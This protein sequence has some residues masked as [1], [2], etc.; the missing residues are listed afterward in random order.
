MQPISPLGVQFRVGAKADFTTPLAAV[1][2]DRTSH[3][4]S[5]TSYC[6]DLVLDVLTPL[7]NGM[8]VGDQN[9][10]R[11]LGQCRAIWGAVR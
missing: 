6:P 9:F 5:A 8:S 1:F 7:S 4:L 11:C 10:W 2:K 3:V